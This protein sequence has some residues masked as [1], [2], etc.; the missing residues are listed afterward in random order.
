MDSFNDKNHLCLVFEMLDMNL[1]EL[2][3]QNQF[4]GLPLSLIRY[5]T[6]GSASISHAFP[7][8]ARAPCGDALD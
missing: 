2:L 4:R 6:Q 3:K 8:I 1:Y 7:Q 5:V